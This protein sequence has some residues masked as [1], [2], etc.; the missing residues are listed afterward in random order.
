MKPH[1]TT[2]QKYPPPPPREKK[3]THFMNWS[4]PQAAQLKIG[5]IHSISRHNGYGARLREVIAMASGVK[6]DK[7]R[8]HFSNSFIAWFQ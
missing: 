1:S 8:R 2:F 5:S 6:N 3:G 7:F 4:A